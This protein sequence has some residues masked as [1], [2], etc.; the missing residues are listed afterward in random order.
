MS[1]LKTVLADKASAIAAGDLDGQTGEAIQNPDG[2]LN[3]Q[4]IAESKVWSVIA[5]TMITKA[6]ELE[7]KMTTVMANSTFKADVG[8]TFQA[9][10]QGL[11]Y[12]NRVDIL[13]DFVGMINSVSKVGLD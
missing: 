2:S 6:D 11:A 12:A 3:L 7:K 1:N 5:T 13:R 8:G 4:Y 9:I 10:L